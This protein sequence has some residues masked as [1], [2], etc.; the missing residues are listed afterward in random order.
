MEFSERKKSN[1][2]IK[3]DLELKN[4]AKKLFNSLG[5]DMTTA[6]NIFLTS[7]INYGGIPFEVKIPNEETIKA[8]EE[9]E[10]DVNM[11]KEYDNVDELIKTILGE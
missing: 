2:H 5:M 4:E 3:T 7:S 10:K 1:I 6:I 8:I 9:S 11:S